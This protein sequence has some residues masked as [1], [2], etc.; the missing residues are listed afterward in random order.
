MKVLIAPDKFKGTLSAAEA[1]AA[2]VRGWRQVR[3]EDQLHLLPMSDGGDGFGE[4]ISALLRAGPQTVKTE[5]AAHRPCETTWWWEAKTKTAIVETAKVIGLAMLPPGKFHP[6]ELDTF[7]LGAVLSAAQEKGAKQILVGIGGSATND[8]GFGLARALGWR[9][10]DN[11][12]HP[13]ERWTELH[14]LSCVHASGLRPFENV[15]VAVDVQ[16]PLLGPRGATRVYGPQ[17]GLRPD[18]FDLAERVAGRFEIQDAGRA[19]QLFFDQPGDAVVDVFRRCTRI[20]GR[21]RDRRRR[22]DR[23]LRDRQLRKCKNSAETNQQRHDP[24]EDGPIDKE[25]GHGV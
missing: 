14:R 2:V 17:K 11:H 16:N 20:A 13:V 22:D 23:I 7:G 12:G 25:A 5:D 21:N 10:V 24:C 4:V 9:F 15:T 1:A 3:P 19:V 18:D 6:F 8:G